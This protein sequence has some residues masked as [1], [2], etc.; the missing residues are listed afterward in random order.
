MKKKWLILCL[1]C[2][3]IFLVISYSFKNTKKIEQETIAV[4]KETIAEKVVAV[5][6]IVPKHTI[7]VK[8]TIPGIVGKL[9]HEEGDYTEKGTLLLQVLPAPTP[10]SV[11]DAHAAVKENL[12]VLR[13]AEEHQKRLK[14]LL[15]MK[16]E[17]P[18]K[19]ALA[20]KDVATAKA[21]LDLSQQ[22]LSL[23]QKG[24]TTIGGK[25]IKTTVQS[26][27]SGYILKRSVD[28]GD[29]VVPLTEA[30]EGTVLFVIANM[31]DLIFKGAV[32]EID[33][34]KIS[35]NMIADVNVAALPDVKI[36][37]KL[38]KVGLRSNNQD[39]TNK[40]PTT[41]NSTSPFNVGFDI[42]LNQLQLPKELKLRAGY[43]ATAEIIVKQVTNA[44]VV[45][46]R[47]LI[48]KDNKIYVNLVA[49]NAK[50]SIQQEIQI[51]ISDG[52]N[53]EVKKGLKEG[54]LIIDNPSETS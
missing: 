4:K 6:E 35:P 47:V 43:S 28:V 21:K 51:G 54:D 38:N 46:E 45:P 48:F 29:P 20:V 19:Y 11:A 12:A 8:S 27:I 17:T 39:T 18:D 44:L 23:L 13:Q 36:K 50:K 41:A 14:Q 5:G 2:V 22:K 53:V 31:Q 40:Q 49:N 9:L 30:Q 10:Q 26:P 32:N 15:S 34:A 25:D 37:G 16:M 7:S 3:I 24:E 52:V 33:V 1:F 42:E